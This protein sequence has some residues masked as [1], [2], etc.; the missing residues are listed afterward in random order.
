MSHTCIGR[1]RLL[2]RLELPTTAVV[3]GRYCSQRHLVHQILQHKG[4]EEAEKRKRR[5]KAEDKPGQNVHKTTVRGSILELLIIG[6][7]FSFYQSE[8]AV[9]SPV[10]YTRVW[11]TNRSKYYRLWIAI[12]LRCLSVL[13]TSLPL[14]DRA[15]KPSWTPTSSATLF[16]DDESCSHRQKN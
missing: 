11:V 14:T 15:R 2:K 13:A 12:C 3:F 5:G 9:A 10:T 8:S 7:H 6:S 1:S 16:M 4:G